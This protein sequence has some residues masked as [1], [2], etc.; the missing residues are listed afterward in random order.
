MHLHFEPASCFHKVTFLKSEGGGEEALADALFECLF[1]CPC[2][3]I[4][5]RVN[6]WSLSSMVVASK[7][8]NLPIYWLLLRN[9]FLVAVLWA[10][11]Y[12]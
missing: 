8:E 7:L 1:R 2:W 6:F 5:T 12:T 9:L 10:Y 11:N 3:R 4:A